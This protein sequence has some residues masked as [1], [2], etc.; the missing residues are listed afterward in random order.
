MRNFI[1]NRKAG[2]QIVVGPD[3]RITIVSVGKTRVKLLIEAPEA[4][5][6]E[7]ILKTEDTEK[8]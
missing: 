8:Q 2:D 7:M 1:T 4:T 6:I 5:P 3:L